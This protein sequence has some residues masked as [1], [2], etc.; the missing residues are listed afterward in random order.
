MNEALKRMEELPK[1]IEEFQRRMKEAEERRVLNA[2]F[3]RW[4][5][6]PYWTKHEAVAL[7]LC[8]DPHQ[9]IRADSL[10]VPSCLQRES[11]DLEDLLERAIKIKELSEELIPA[12][13]LRWLES[14]KVGIPDELSKA[15][16]EVSPLAP[17]V[18][19]SAD[20]DEE[21]CEVEPFVK[22]EKEEYRVQ[23]IL[24]AIAAKGWDP[25]NIPHGGKAEIEKM[26]LAQAGSARYKLF[27]RSTFAKAWQSALRSKLVRTD[28]HED[29]AKR[30]V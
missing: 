16:A 29:Y 2:Q 12:T 17:A 14:K 8:F 20:A 23:A 4:A 1:R 18:P 28:K 27:S 26:C 3:R 25:M 5:R 11:D 22:G 6:K 15:V 13:L 7:L 21:G 10:N 19:V 9:V 30:G 24:S